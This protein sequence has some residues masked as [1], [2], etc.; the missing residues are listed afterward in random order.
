MKN[1]TEKHGVKYYSYDTKIYPFQKLVA[2]LF[3][4]D[5]LTEVHKKLQENYDQILFTNEQDD[6]TNLHQTFYSK[7]NAGWKEFEETYKNFI[8]NEVR[9]VFQ[10]EQIIYQTKPTFRVQLPGNIAV[11]GN[12][13]DSKEKYG[14]HK[15]T[16]ENYNHPNFEK[17]FIIPLTRARE[18]ASVFIET[19]P[20]SDEFKPAIMNVGEFFQFNG[21]SC[22]HGNKKNITGKSRVSLDF[23]IVLPQDYNKQYSGSS[24]LSKKKFIIGHYYSKIGVKKK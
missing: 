5:D 9:E 15:D 11:G 19:S 13:N 20:Q 17:N 4:I 12:E 1:I 6:R 3:T 16:D 18:T 24:K 23:R 8:L 14:W 10:T 2:N 21:G 7:L 22:I